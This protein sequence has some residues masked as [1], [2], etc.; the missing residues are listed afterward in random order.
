MD[1]IFCLLID[2]KMFHVAC[3]VTN[4]IFVPLRHTW[5]FN[6]SM[7][8]QHRDMERL[9]AMG[10]ER[11]MERHME[12][13][14]G[15]EIPRRRSW[16]LNSSMRSQRRATRRLGVENILYH[17]VATDQCKSRTAMGK[18]RPPLGQMRRNQ[19]LRRLC[20]SVPSPATEC[21]LT[22]HTRFT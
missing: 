18:S 8:S 3:F 9:Q 11:R 22:D 15:G 2:D 16:H 20:Q 1:D 4:A 12:R 17:L 6:S 7:R 21:E 13:H 10:V 14:M 19:Q 5:H